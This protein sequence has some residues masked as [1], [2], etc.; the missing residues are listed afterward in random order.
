MESDS[1]EE[2]VAFKDYVAEKAC[3]T[4]PPP[5]DK[6]HPAVDTFIRRC[7]E[8]YENLDCSSSKHSNVTFK[9]QKALKSLL[10]RDDLVVK[11][12]DKGG[13]IVVLTRAAYVAEAERQLSDTTF[14]RKESD[15]LTM[16]N[17]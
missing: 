2:D 10:K 4:F 14:Y 8:E 5:A 7:N 17:F 1:E 12:A 13:A 15:D 16:T 11:P 6:V 3:S 9:Q